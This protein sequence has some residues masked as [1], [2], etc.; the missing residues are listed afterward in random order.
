MPITK[1]ARERRREKK[2][3]TYKKCKKGIL[4]NNNNNNN[5]L[6]YVWMCI[7]ALRLQNELEATDCCSPCR[8]T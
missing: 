1:L 6:T 5:S 7:I 4:Y 8:V 3:K 2:Q